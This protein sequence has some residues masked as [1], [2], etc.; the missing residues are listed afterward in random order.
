VRAGCRAVAAAAGW[1]ARPVAGAAAA[2]AV[3]AS[4]TALPEVNRFMPTP[5]K[6]GDGMLEGTELSAIREALEVAIERPAVVMFGPRPPAARFKEPVYNTDTAW[7]D[8]AAVVRARDLGPA[9]NP[10]IVG[11]YA[12]RQPERT[13][14][15]YEWDTG[16]FRKL[17]RADE[18]R[19]KLR[20][21][22]T[23]EAVMNPPGSKAGGA[24]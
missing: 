4:V 9:Q 10:E 13:F 17:G 14:Y 19:R 6:P 15:H 18:L 21:G 8:D 3:A 1:W 2:L 5:G 20:D 11:Y 22:A 16:T 7:P 23:W 24:P 12:A